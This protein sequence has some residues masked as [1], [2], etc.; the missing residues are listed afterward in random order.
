MKKNTK[1][2]EYKALPD[3]FVG[4]DNLFKMAL[5]A[6]VQ[7]GN[8]LKAKGLLFFVVQKAKADLQLVNQAHDIIDEMMEALPQ[9]ILS[10][11]PLLVVMKVKYDT[12]GQSAAVYSSD[13]TKLDA[14]ML[15]GVPALVFDTLQR[16]GCKPY[17]SLTSN[18]PQNRNDVFDIRISL[19]KEKNKKS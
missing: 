14:N 16:A 17:L 15:R 6:A 12:D 3:T 1:P 11:E 13:K 19:K 7:T 10:D 5:E 8:E 2:K 18:R 4:N 9:A